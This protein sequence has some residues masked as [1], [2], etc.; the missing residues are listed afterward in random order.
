MMTWR[1]PRWAIPAAIGGVLA[2]AAV[3]AVLM[4]RHPVSVRPLA[5]PEQIGLRADAD[6]EGMRVQW[7]R[8][9]RSI[10]NADHAILYIEDGALQSQL[11]LTGRQLDSSTVRY[12]PESERVNFRLQV[13]RGT[14]SSSDSAAFG[15]PQARHR[16]RQPG[17]A[18]AM[19]EQVRPSPFEHV[20][21][22]I[23]VT[24]TLPPPVPVEPERVAATLEPVVAAAEPPKESRLDRMI[25]RIPLLRR[26]RKHP[27]SD[28]TQPR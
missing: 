1:I 26:L 23:E 19:V 22:E 10:R 21:P 28:E 14:Q 27:P 24:Q 15:L 16:R 20:Q 3:D 18:R 4:Q 8:G 9:S 2:V 13:Y 5:I 12:W 11:D 25:S 7:N 6:G 17:P